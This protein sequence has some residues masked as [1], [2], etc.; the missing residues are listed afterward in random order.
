[1]LV[2][3]FAMAARTPLDSDMWW[4]L[5]AGEATLQ[6][7]RPVLDDA[8]SFTR[9]GMAWVNHSWLAQV[10]M[11]LTYRLGGMIGLSAL[12]AG[13]ASFS[14]GLVYLQMEGPGLMR[15]FILVLAAAVAAPVWSPRPQ[16]TSLVLF[17]ALGYLLYL[18]KWR[19]VDR[20][21]LLA[22]LF[23]LWSNL[24]GGYVLGLLLIA[25]MAGG[26]MLNHLLGV[27]EPQVLSWGR[28][29]HLLAWGAAGGLLVVANPNGLAMWSIPFQTVNL[30][31]LQTYIPEWAAPDFHQLAQQPFLWLLLATLGVAGLS[32]RRLDGT[33]LAGVA[34][35]AVLALLARRNF[36][37]F[38]MLAAPVLSRHLHAL[39]LERRSAFTR[40]PASANH[41]HSSVDPPMRK[42]ARLFYV[43]LITVLSLF[44][45]AKLYLVA[46]PEFVEQAS[47][48]L[49]PAGAVA[50]LKSN[51]PPGPIFN[52]YAWGG[53][54][55]WNL[56]EYPVFVDGRT[57]LFGD[58]FLRA[59]VLAYSG[60]EGWQEILDQYGVNLVVVD[61]EAGL[62]N[63]M[64]WSL[65]WRQVFLDEVAVVFIRE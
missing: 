33:D 7:G 55:E 50:W 36:G 2:L 56:P 60:E 34:L 63:E 22:P 59:Y 42:S 10:G 31:A 52:D 14:L 21:W 28:L 4:H 43:L 3:V 46:R 20:L 9:A 5:R 1:V 61:S 53:Y 41:L 12:V 64:H 44:S 54:L 47:R 32:P 37:P 48:N 23:V 19:Q 24:H 45:L 11:A 15:A 58:D 40:W 17:G 26:E 51:R 65:A 57:D 16:L 29:L 39:L 27:A 38:A 8:F 62:V 13:L 49:Y 18:Y 30:A 6:S 25:A 35:F